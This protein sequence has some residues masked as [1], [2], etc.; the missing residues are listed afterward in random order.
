[1]RHVLK[2]SVVTLLLAFCFLPA[3]YAARTVSNPSLEADANRDSVPD[4]WMKLGYGT[5][6]FRFARTTDAHSGTYAERV[7]ITSLISG[8]RKLVIKQDSGAC[9]LQVTPRQTYRLSAWYK[10]NVPTDFVLFTRKSAGNWGY[11]KSSRL[12]P[13]SAGWSRV[14]W[15]TP[16]IP[17]GVT[18]LSF[19]LNL[20][21]AGTL[22]VDDLSA[23][24]VSTQPTPQ[25]T[26][27]PDPTPPPSG[28]GA[29]C[30]TRPVRAPP[31]SDGDAARSALPNP[32]E[33]V[34]DNAAYNQRVPTADEL[35]AFRAKA[36]T[37]DWGDRPYNPKVTGN[38]TGT[39]DELISWAAC[40]WGIDEDTIRAVTVQESDRRQA[41]RGDY[42]NC[43]AGYQSKGITQIKGRY[44]QCPDGWYGT[45]PL[46][47]QSTPF[48]LD[49]YGSRIRMCYDG[50]LNW[51]PY[52]SGDLW[53]CVGWW[54]SG[55]WHDAGAEDYI[56]KV[57]GHLVSRAW[58]AY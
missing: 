6:S 47:E 16:P 30:G 27:T 21:E 45:V 53:G 12:F 48:N 26:P 4:C 34:P 17:E 43:I 25:P 14:T 5:N 40:K 3:A 38:H 33:R 41:M 19:G 36:D 56:A 7:K 23:S 42:H 52:P 11:W 28:A 13:A 50:K 8:D 49:Y 9:A 2:G 24:Q 37:A 39:T 51:W 57:R 15:T 35:S 1:M 54:F 20:M 44:P 55:G 22:T 58:T 29:Y 31:L 10:S 18:H 32:T 46:N